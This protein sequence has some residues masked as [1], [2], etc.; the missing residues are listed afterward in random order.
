ML[1]FRPALMI[2]NFVRGTDERSRMIRRSCVRYLVLLQAMVFRDVSTPVKKRFPTMQHVVTA[3]ITFLFQRHCALLIITI[4]RLITPKV[5]KLHL[6]CKNKIYV[7][8]QGETRIQRYYSGFYGSEHAQRQ[9][10]NI[11]CANFS[12]GTML[13][14]LYFTAQCDVH[15]AALLISFTGSNFSYIEAPQKSTNTTINLMPFEAPHHRE[16]SLYKRILAIN[17][18]FYETI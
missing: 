16:S 15:I 7:R 17:S 18:L 4:R 13:S 6:S 11:H 12:R 8:A 3:G 10:T 2:A 9:N 5:K 14:Q 1:P